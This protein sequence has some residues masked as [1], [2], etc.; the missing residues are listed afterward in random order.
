V[1]GGAYYRSYDAANN[2]DKSFPATISSFRL[3]RFE[4]TVGRFRKFTAAWD[5]GFRPA[6]GA[7]KHGHLNGGQGLAASA[8]G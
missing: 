5:G 3:D 1:N 2:K 4:V 6:A 8:G 7:G